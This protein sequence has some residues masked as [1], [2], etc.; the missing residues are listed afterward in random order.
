MRLPQIE[1]Q[2]HKALEAANHKAW[3]AFSARLHE[4]N[5]RLKNI[6]IGL[7]E[8]GYMDLRWFFDPFPITCEEQGVVSWKMC[9]K[10]YLLFDLLETD[11]TV[12]WKPSK[13]TNHEIAVMREMLQMCEW[14]K[15]E[16]MPSRT[17]VFMPRD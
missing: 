17:V 13:I 14:W 12:G 16:R 10:Y 7:I 1:K 6:R 3:L 4:L 5:A 15:R 8:V 2:Y 9:N 11:T